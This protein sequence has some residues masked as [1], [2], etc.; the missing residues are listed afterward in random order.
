MPT[1]SEAEMKRERAEA[2]FQRMAAAG[3]ER[4]A[5]RADQE[6]EAVRVAAKTARLKALRLA[7]EAAVGAAAPAQPVKGAR[8]KKAAPRA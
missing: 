3:K 7:N 5:A 8:K 6:A 1:K 4:S 2:R